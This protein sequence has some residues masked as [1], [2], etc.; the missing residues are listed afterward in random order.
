MS[1]YHAH[2]EALACSTNSICVLCLS[3][4]AIAP[5]LSIVHRRMAER[6]G[7]QADL[8]RKYTSCLPVLLACARVVAHGDGA[9]VDGD[10]GDLTQM[11]PEPSA[12]T[13]GLDA[14]V[15]HAASTLSA[16]GEF[17]KDAT[18][19]ADGQHLGQRAIGVGIVNSDVKASDDEVHLVRYLLIR[20]SLGLLGAT[21]HSN[22]RS[23]P[24]S[25]GRRHS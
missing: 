20:F 23:S 24:C 9:A 15:L 8:S 19:L 10:D 21:K 18:M 13:N 3:I 16:L 1:S 7:R 11:E 22:S 5:V 4:M 2:A 17:V 6:G 14:N 25:C 12:E